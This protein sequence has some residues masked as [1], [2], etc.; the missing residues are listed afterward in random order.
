MS[1]YGDGTK[2]Q[3]TYET[4][5]NLCWEIY[6]K[7]LDELTDAEKLEF[8]GRILYVIQNE[9]KEFDFNDD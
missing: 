4:I 5:E 3:Y 6:N 7:G 1:R 2:R 9:I 8:I